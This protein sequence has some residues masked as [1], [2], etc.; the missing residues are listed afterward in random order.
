MGGVIGPMLVSSLLATVGFNGAML[1]FA[2]L[3][4]FGAECILLHLHSTLHH[5][6]PVA[7]SNSPCSLSQ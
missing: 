7:I 6:P 2:A 5:H 3:S 4:L 1:S